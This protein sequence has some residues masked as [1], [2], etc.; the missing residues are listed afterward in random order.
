MRPRKRPCSTTPA[1]SASSTASAG[2]VG[3]GAEV[4][5]EDD[6]ARVGPVGSAPSTRRSTGRPPRPPRNALGGGQAEGDHLHGEGEPRSSRG[7]PTAS[8]RRPRSPRAGW[9]APRSSP[10][11]APRRR[12]SP[13]PGAGST[14][15]APSMVRSISHGTSSARQAGSRAGGRRRRSA[16]DV[17]TAT[18]SREL[19]RGQARARPRAR[20]T[21]PSIRCRA[22]PPCPTR[23]TPPARSAAGPLRRRDVVGSSTRR[24]CARYLRISAFVE[25]S[26]PSGAS[27]AA[28]SSG[29]IR[30]ASTLPSST[31]H[32]SKLLMRQIV[33]WVNTLCS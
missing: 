3:D 24:R 12:P 17:G 13:V 1:W 21:P 23:P 15:S 19:A 2:G 20:P 6:V 16:V 25:L 27:V 33:P 5:V 29:M 32:W 11:A 30:C 10:A 9:P 14:S 8:S 22:P 26:W 31:P 4:A 7:R 28:C 18:M